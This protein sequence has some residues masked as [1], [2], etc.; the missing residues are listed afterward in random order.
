MPTSRTY[1][2]AQVSRSIGVGLLAGGAQRTAA[3]IRVPI[4]RWPSPAR[5]LVRLAARPAR[6][7]AANR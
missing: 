1:Q 2:A 5:M 7:S 6:H 3:I 4:R